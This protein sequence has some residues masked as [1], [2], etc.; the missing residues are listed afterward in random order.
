MS[1]QASELTIREITRAKKALLAAKTLLNEDL[2]EDAV[3]RA[4][5]AVLHAAKAALA[6]IGIEADTHIKVRK[7]FSLHLVKPGKIEK[8]Y[9]KMLTAEQEDR[10]IGE[11][12]VYIDIE[13][14]RAEPR[15]E[16]AKDFVVTIEQYLQ[17]LKKDM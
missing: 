10:E 11:Y 8:K 3:S 17:G 14:E 6:V 7:M 4:Y 12:D 9:A 2:Y 1:N 13:K 15:V 16:E 5:Y